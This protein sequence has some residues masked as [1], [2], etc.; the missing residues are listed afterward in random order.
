M[1]GPLSLSYRNYA[2]G[3]S[4]ANKFPGGVTDIQH[5]QAIF[6]NDQFLFEQIDEIFHTV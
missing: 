4:T 5:Q 2:V 1:R 3:T 6:E